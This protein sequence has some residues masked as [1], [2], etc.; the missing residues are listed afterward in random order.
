[1][2]GIRGD[3]RYFRLFD[4]PEGLVLRDTGFFDYWRISIGATFSWPIR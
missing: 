2:F 1:V 3:V 4:R